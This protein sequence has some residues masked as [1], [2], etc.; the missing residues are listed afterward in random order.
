MCKCHGMIF[1]GRVTV[2]ELDED[3][4]SSMRVARDG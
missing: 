3:G 2:G 4:L 1:G